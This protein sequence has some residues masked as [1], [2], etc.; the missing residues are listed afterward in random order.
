MQNPQP[1]QAERQVMW[2]CTPVSGGPFAVLLE[3]G[4]VRSTWHECVEETHSVGISALSAPRVPVWIQKAPGHLPVRQG[5][6]ELE[7]YFLDFLSN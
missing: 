3:D 6:C 5:T 4:Q 7:G 2:L 1:N